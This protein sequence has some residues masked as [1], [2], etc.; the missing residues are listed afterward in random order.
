MPLAILFFLFGILLFQQT[1]TSPDCSWL[2]AAMLLPLALWWPAIRLPLASLAGFLWALLHACLILGNALPAELEGV[3]VEITGTV[4]SLPEQ[5]THHAR[6]QFDLES[7]SHNGKS[8]DS[9]KRVLLSWYGKRPEL[10]AGERWRL[11]VRLKRPHGFMNPGGFDY[12]GWLYRQHIDAT[13]YVRHK[14]SYSPLASSPLLHPLD[15][16]RQ[17]LQRQLADLQG[18]EPYLGLIGALAIGDRSA[19]QPQQWQVLRATGTNH[20]MA[21]SGL[22]IGLVAGMAFFLG[23][24]IWGLLGR[25]P[26]RLPATKA[27]ALVAVLAASLYASLAGF[28]IPT[29]RALIMILVVMGAL[30]LQRQLSPARVLVVALAG[31][32]V[33][34][35]LAVLATGFWLSF[36]AVAVIL[37]G[38]GGRLQKGP[39]WRQWG[40]VQW[41]VSLGLLPLLMLSFHQAPLLSPLANLV[42]VPWVSLLVVPLILLGVAGLLLYPPLGS[43]LLLQAAHLLGWLWPLLEWFAN[44]EGGVWQPATAP[45]PWALIAAAIGVLWILA[46]RGIPARWAGVVWTLPLILARPSH[47][48]QGEVWFTLLD[49]GQGLAAVVQ[50]QHHTLIYDTGPRFNDRFD[51]GQAVLI[52]FLRQQ[53][54]HHLDI[55]IIGHGDNDHIGGAHSLLQRYH[56][57]HILTTVPE[58]LP[59]MAEQCNRGQTWLWD[60]IRFSILHPSPGDRPQGNNASCVLKVETSAGDGLLLTG[61]IERRAE[62]QLVTA[63]PSALHAKILIAPHHGSKSSSSARFIEAVAPEYVLFPVGYRN[64]FH[65]PHPRVVM[66]YR[67]RG[68]R[69]LDSATQGAIRFKM[70]EN[71]VSRP[72]SYRLSARHYWNAR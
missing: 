41:V 15:R 8:Y 53:G 3:D 2:F 61:D 57:D 22:H 67:A 33:L 32:L 14:S 21:I 49:V 48:H 12:E 31:V 50:T 43:W 59:P 17:R 45:T 35:P 10:S 19:I 20:L 28:S 11:T 36:A 55:L 69:M 66:R 64:R 39:G 24:R 25:A 54:I 68:V 62:R 72:E 63:N 47:P 18:G 42:A 4:S 51:T 13:G 70:D 71:G 56:P 7:L 40:Q 9:P 52:P 16:L 38:L 58:K 37:Y 27:G 30:L 34:D 44:I 60:G 5:G 6:F 46:P 23:R 29:Q 26:L 65:H 1:T